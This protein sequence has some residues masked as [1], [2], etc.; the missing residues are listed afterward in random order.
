MSNFI[1]V[2]FMLGNPQPVVVMD[3]NNGDLC[4]ERAQAVTE[5]NKEFRAVCQKRIDV[6][7]V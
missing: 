4:L 3:F 6:E 7:T 1:L 2:I 5:R